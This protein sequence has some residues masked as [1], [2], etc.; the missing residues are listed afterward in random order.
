M[1]SWQNLEKLCSCST[2]CMV[3]ALECGNEWIQV[4]TYK[5][6]PPAPAKYLCSYR[7]L[8]LYHAC[9]TGRIHSPLH[10][11]H[12]LTVYT[13]CCI[14]CIFYTKSFNNNLNLHMEKQLSQVTSNLD[15]RSYKVKKVI[16]AFMSGL[17]TDIGASLVEA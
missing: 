2:T 4:G 16:E 17:E 13:A 11:C 8:R 7:V 12:L 14:H 5:C 6:S 3:S 15:K 10:Q 1:V 9:S